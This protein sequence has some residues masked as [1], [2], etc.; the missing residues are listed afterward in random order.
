MRS[1]EQ[2][3]HQPVMEANFPGQGSGADGA[4]ATA[5]HADTPFSSRLTT[6]VSLLMSAP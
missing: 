5:G 3:A 4:I 1:R 6:D 2:R